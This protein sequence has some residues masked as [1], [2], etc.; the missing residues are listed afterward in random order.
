MSAS[1]PTK[2]TQKG[3]NTF[4]YIFE[5][6][7]RQSVKEE[8]ADEKTAVRTSKTGNKVFENRYSNVEGRLV[9]IGVE[10]KTITKNGK[11]EQEDELQL[12]IKDKYG[13]VYIKMGLKSQYA[14]DLC[15]K[16]VKVDF[17]QDIKVY[18]SFFKDEG[19]YYFS[20]VQN[21]VKI[22]NYFTK[23]TPNGLPQPSVFVKSDKTKV[24][25]FG[26]QTLFFKE[27]IMRIYL[28]NVKAHN[29]GK[30]LLIDAEKEV[31]I[32]A[33]EFEAKAKAKAKEAKESEA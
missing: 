33:K 17:G 5:G 18:P 29:E 28:P 14:S 16:L 8:E 13:V 12:K 20:V 6:E 2:E 23:E 22:K 25:D 7:L 11:P 21:D 4:M 1:R 26:E 32:I 30:D 10:T 3:N 24:Y 19:K 27:L 31:K 9:G 15:K